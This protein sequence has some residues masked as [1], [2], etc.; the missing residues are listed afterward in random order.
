MPRRA[1]DHSGALRASRRR[2]ASSGCIGGGDAQA[3]AGSHGVLRIQREIEYRRFKLGRIGKGCA[4]LRIEIGHD[5]DV[6]AHRAPQ[7]LAGRVEF[8]DQALGV[9]QDDA[10][11]CGFDDG[12]QPCRLRIIPFRPAILAA[13]WQS[14]H[15]APGPVPDTHECG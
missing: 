15:G 2:R 10:I 12:P 7:Q 4:T 6:F 14:F 8:H 11:D 3:S 9:D 1:R 13:H 5:L